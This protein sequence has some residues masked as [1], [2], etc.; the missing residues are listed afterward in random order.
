MQYLTP[1]IGGGVHLCRRLRFRAELASVITGALELLT[2]E[3]SWEGF[4]DMT[5]AEAAELSTEALNYYLDSG[6]GCMIGIPF[7]YLTADPPFGSLPC[8]GSTHDV[9]DYPELYAALADEIR[10]TVAETYTLPDLR[11]RTI[12]GAG[13]GTGLTPRAVGEELGAESVALIVAELPAHSHAYD[14]IAATLVDP[15]ATPSIIGIDDI[16]SVQ[17]GETGGGEAHQNM[18]P[19]T[20]LPMAVWYR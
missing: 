9:A 15:G 3:Y 8:D 10:D 6:D 1:D 11:G 18:Q 12:I 20:A 2:H 17:T 4:G 19:S 5:P 13:A 16:N 14:Q 7:P